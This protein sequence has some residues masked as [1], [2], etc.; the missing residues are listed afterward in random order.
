MIKE[1]IKEEEEKIN[2]EIQKI[3]E[4]ISREAE[5]PLYTVYE[6]KNAIYYVIDVPFINEKTIYIKFE[7]N[8]YIKLSCKNM[9]GKDYQLIIPTKYN[10]ENYDISVI[11]NKGFIK[12]VLRKKIV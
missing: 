6:D 5:E 2:R 12:L 4:E 3:E 1:I 10:F 9:R 11:R 8:K 7:S